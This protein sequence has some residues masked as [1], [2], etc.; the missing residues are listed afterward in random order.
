VTGL[1][2][3]NERGGDGA[4]DKAGARKPS[5]SRPAEGVKLPFRFEKTWSVGESR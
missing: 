3:D 1:R 5:L 2:G 4:E